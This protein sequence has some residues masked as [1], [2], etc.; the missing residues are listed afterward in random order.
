VSNEQ[1]QHLALVINELTANSIKHA[2]NRQGGIQIKIS[3]AESGSKIRLVYQ[4]D[5]PGYPEALVAGDF[6]AANVGFDLILGIV[7]KSL[8]GEL[9]LSNDSGAKASIIFEKE[10]DPGEPETLGY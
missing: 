5:G 8:R 2:L 3:I 10:V 7:V 6:S 4:D 9:T 1:A